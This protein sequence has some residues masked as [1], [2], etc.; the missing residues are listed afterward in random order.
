MD[1]QQTERRLKLYTNYLNNLYDLYNKFTNSNC[2]AIWDGWVL[3]EAAGMTQNASVR[4]A[5]ENTVWGM[6]DLE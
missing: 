6:P 4:I 2:L 3:G 1:I 5:T